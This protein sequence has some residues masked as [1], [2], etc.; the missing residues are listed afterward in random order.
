MCG[1]ELNPGADQRKHITIKYNTV[2][3]DETGFWTVDQQIESYHVKFPDL[4]NYIIL[5]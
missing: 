2:T 4:E 1:S 5:L 3:I